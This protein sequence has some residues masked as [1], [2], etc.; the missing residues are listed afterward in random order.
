MDYAT[1]VQG[2]EA[3]ASTSKRLEKT[4]HVAQLLRKTPADSLKEVILLLQGKVFPIWD[5]RKIGVAVMLVQ[6]AIALATATTPEHITTLWKETGDLGMTIEQLFGKKRQ[7]TLA[8][9]S[10]L[11][12]D[13]FD[14]IQ[15]LAT[16]E[17]TKS[18]ETKLKLI[19]KLLTSATPN[20]ARYI[21]RTVLEDLRVGAGEG[22]LRDAICWAFAP[23]VLGILVPCPHCKQLVPQADD[24]V[25]CRKSLEFKFQELFDALTK[26]AGLC[27]VMD[28]T[29]AQ[30]GKKHYVLVPKSEEHA[31]QTYNVLLERIQ[32]AFD[33][34]NDFGQVASL[35]KERGM[36]GLETLTI[37]PGPPLNLML[38]QKADTIEQGFEIVG[39][40]C[41]L[42]YKYDGFRIEIHKEDERITLYTRRLEDVTPMFPDI[43]TSIQTLVH[44][45]ACILDAEVVGV[46]SKGKFLSFQHISKRIRRKYDIDQMAKEIPV[47]VNIFDALYLDGKTLLKE[48]YEQRRKLLHSIVKEKKNVLVLAEQV[49]T[50]KPTTAQR[51][52]E[53]AL[54]MGNEGIMMK[55]LS[56][57]YKPGKRMGYG[58]K[59]KPTMENLDLVIVEA[60]WGE[61]KRSGSLTSFT[62]ACKDEDDN[63]L[64]I[65][66]M[67]TG[68]KEKKTEPDDVTYDDMTSLLKEHILSESG[69]VVTLSPSLVIEV[70]Y[71]EIQASQ[72]NASGFA[73]RFPRF[74]R[75]REDRSPHEISE[76][77][78]IENL[79]TT[80]RNRGV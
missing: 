68:I 13:V 71:E 65:G 24:C 19:A 28:I 2:Y 20:E 1:L 56:G 16:I 67:S 49:V 33:I 41:A 25:A 54:E 64:E 42:E 53:K 15:K 74:V 52:Y 23:N 78:F 77:A 75:L 66:R 10:L 8:S 6:K 70:A 17:G 76:L 69:K 50:D 11:V 59:I 45:R 29:E 4:Y 27:L 79:F 57:I 51:F 21:V 72:T 37:T 18:V 34:V 73:L 38:Y 32:E 5:Q 39:T 30:D 3:L 7:M 62:L 47:C 46:D 63:L 9:D 55:N 35:L 26:T 40:P 14:T 22:V 61:G 36:S 12:H 31:R 43:V 48:T 58:V 80:Q 44:A 60:E